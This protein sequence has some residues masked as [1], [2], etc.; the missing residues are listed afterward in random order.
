MMAFV[1]G[2]LLSCP[3]CA[4]R[5]SAS[6]KNHVAAVLSF[7]GQHTH[8]FKSRL[9]RADHFKKHRQKLRIPDGALYERVYERIADRFLG[10]PLSASSQEFIRPWN[11]DLVRYDAKHEVVGI[12]D[13]SVYIK[14]YFRPHPAD[15]GF[16]SNMSYFN[17]E[18]AKT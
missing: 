9:H 13:S 15:H 3:A 17:S 1:V 8:G 5:L 4:V 18:K 2:D 7:G 6:A 14:T 16:A 12:L 11:N 10:R